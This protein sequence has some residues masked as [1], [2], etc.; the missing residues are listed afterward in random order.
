MDDIV[1]FDFTT[2]SPKIIKVIGV[3]KECKIGRA[4]V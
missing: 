3:G 2:D 1:Q 4:H